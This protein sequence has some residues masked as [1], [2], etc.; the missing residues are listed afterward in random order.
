MEKFRFSSQLLG[1]R[2]IPGSPAPSNT[3]RKR[4][5][6]RKHD[7]YSGLANKF[8]NMKDYG[9]NMEKYEENMIEF[10]LI[11]KLRVVVFLKILTKTNNS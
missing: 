10:Y 1:P 11:A 8:S 7:I 3:G 4:G 9:E 6:D 5:E 2:K